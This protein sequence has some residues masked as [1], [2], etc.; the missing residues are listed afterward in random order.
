MNIVPS[1]S[2]IS[3]PATF[4][5]DVLIHGKLDIGIPGTGGGLDV[6]EGGS[7][8]NDSTGTTVVK[9][10]K[11]DASADTG[12][13]F[14]EFADLDASNTWLG[15]VGDRFYIG[16]PHLWWAARFNVTTAVVYGDAAE[17]IQAKYYNGSDMT[18]CDHMGIN[19]DDADSIGEQILKQTTQKEYASLQN[20]IDGDWVAADNITDKIP[21]TGTALFWVCF[22]VPATGFSTA[23]IVDEIRVRGTDLDVI[24]NSGFLVFWGKARTEQHE[25]I[26]LVVA[27]SPG[28]TGTADIPID[29]NHNQIVFDF[30]GADEISFLWTLPQGID[31]SSPIKL[32]LGYISDAIDTYDL[33]VFALKLKNATLTGSGVSSSYT[34]TTSITSVAADTFYN[35]IDLTATK[36]SIQD[37]AANDT[38][39][40]ELSR[41]D[42]TNSIY[43]MVITIRYV[44]W[45][46]GEHV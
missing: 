17:I 13:R 6:G 45:T 34:Q 27:R 39:S 23:P 24:T 11:Y 12:L 3:S 40:F 32:E 8:K 15:A 5:S 7:Y 19:K 2:I 30:N 36:M 20:G 9:A 46:T 26:N 16:S 25:R 10:F 29:T 31:L 43:P 28:G 14:T 4:L 22:E 21:N 41:T 35:G 18:A 37:L 1:N 33:V 44:S 38:I 42:T